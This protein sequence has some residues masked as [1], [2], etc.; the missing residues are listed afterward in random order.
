MLE[1]LRKGAGSWVAKILFAILVASFA[2]WGI[3]DVFR[4]FGG[5]TLATVGTTTL[6]PP[7]YEQLFNRELQAAREKFGRQLTPQQGRALGL[8]QQV[9]AGLL[10]DNHVESLGL[11][12]SS[13]AL[14][15]RIQASPAFHGLGGKFDPDRLRE[16]MRS[17]GLSE[18]GFMAVERRQA[19]REQALSALAGDIGAPSILIDAVNRY[20][21]EKRVLDYFMLSAAQVAAPPTPDDAALGAY[22]EAHKRDY[23]IPEL[24]RL[25][26]LE[27]D[28]EALKST[29]DIAEADLE[30]YY[31]AQ[32][33]TFDTPERRRVQQIVFADKAAA[34]KAHA[35]L[36]SGKSF[37]DVAREAGRSESDIDRGLVTQ[38]GLFDPAV[39]AAAFK[40][41]DGAFSEPIEGDLSVSIVKV[42]KIEPAVKKTYADV[43][44]EIR[45]RLALEKATGLLQDLYDK[46]EDL[47]AQGTA[48]KDIA[49]SLGLRYSEV[50]GVTRAGTDADGKPVEAARI[51]ANLVQIAFESDVGIETEPQERTKGG[52]VWIDV[53]EVIPERDKP[54]DEVKS[55]VAEAYIA[56]ERGKALAEKAQALVKRA[57]A[58]E[59]LAA[60]ATE[61]GTTV[62]TSDPL[63]RTSGS[64]D[65]P[66][67]ALPLAFSLAKDAAGDAPSAD[68]SE[69]VIFRLKSI[70]PPAALTEDT[71][72]NVTAR[73]SQLRAADLAGEYVAGLQQRYGLEINQALYQRLYGQTDQ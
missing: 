51:A 39:G 50:D 66:E 27:A 70:E 47:R 60:L 19:L 44:A 5:N 61:A 35:E 52:Y 37:V 41:A 31:K 28:P 67:T 2:L 4:G 20:Q 57:N 15:A 30:A 48:L 11:G 14:L 64:P 45:D 63:T 73:L 69:H 55:A 18:Q 65:L 46:V 56:A 26:L 8:D 12:I 17:N 62:K 10:I 13:E 53:V 21:N 32:E 34:D 23:R 40:L 42:D 71:R 9:F 33:K 59:D 54:L 49:T 6:T 16:V 68:R 22:Y 43:K 29:I 38:D 1:A 36:I 25:A 58:G 72:K 24:R 7:V 3:G